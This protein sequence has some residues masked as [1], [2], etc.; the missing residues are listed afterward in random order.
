MLLYIGA[1]RF[2]PYEAE[3][4]S[5]LVSNSP[6]MAWTYSLFSI[7]GLSAVIGISEVV[8]AVFVEVGE[9]GHH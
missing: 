2:L 4:I 7:R 5:G 9:T 8:I 6:L 3:G 1:L